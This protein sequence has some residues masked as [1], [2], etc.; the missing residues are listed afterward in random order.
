MDVVGVNTFSTHNR[1]PNLEFGS[2]DHFFLK[3]FFNVFPILIN[4]GGDFIVFRAA[5]EFFRPL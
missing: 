3:S 1:L 5:L 2:D 4:I